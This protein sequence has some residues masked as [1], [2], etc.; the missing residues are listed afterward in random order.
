[1]RNKH[2]LQR[3]YG[4]IIT[5]TYTLQE[6]ETEEPVKEQKMVLKQVKR[7]HRTA[8][9][10]SVRSYDLIECLTLTERATMHT[11]YDKRA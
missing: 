5:E 6:E 8:L 11:R 7:I 10:I 4:H 9:K 1:M 2:N 3:F